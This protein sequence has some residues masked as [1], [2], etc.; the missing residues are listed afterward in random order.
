MRR[1]H[2]HPD[3]TGT[4]ERNRDPD[5][6]RRSSQ[7]TGLCPEDSL[8]ELKPTRKDKDSGRVD[9]DE[10]GAAE[11]FELPGADLSHEQ[12]RVEVKPKRAD[13]FTCT[14]CF[15]VHH[16]LALASPR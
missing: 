10:E 6:V 15:L 5:L 3:R 16:R 8:D 2:G 7:A 13:L 4:P 1:T 9:H 12:L 14:H 11:S